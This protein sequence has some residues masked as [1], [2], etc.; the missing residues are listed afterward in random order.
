[1]GARVLEGIDLRRE[2]RPYIDCLYAVLTA[3]GKFMG[4]KYMLSGMTGFAFIFSA[5]KDL[6]IA[7]TE[8]YGLRTA[9]FNSLDILGYYSEVYC[10]LK[11]N[12]TFPLHQKKAVARA[13][14]SIDAGM[15]V[16]VWAPGITDFGVIFGY[17]DEDEVFF[18]KD[19]YHKD[20]QILLYNNLGRVEANFWMCQIIGESI[21][22]DIRDIYLDSLELA[23]DIWETPYIDETVHNRALASGRKAY[24]YLI[25]GMTAGD[26]Y[27]AGVGKLIYYNAMAREEAYRYMENVLEEYAECRPAYLKYKELYEIY[28]QALTLLPSYTA[29]GCNYKIDRSK[30]PKLIECCRSA[31]QTEEDAVSELKLLLKER[32]SNRYID[33]LDVKKFK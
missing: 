22:K 5:H 17:D 11:S 13:K 20:T 27:D 32:L 24:E 2:S 12:L 29:W 14:E 16:I 4:S 33:I 6:I 10:G 18:Y 25:E 7:S 9:A 19:R 26:F 28:Q 21:E 1:M 31:Q 8:M 30:L 23:V 3:S 15:G